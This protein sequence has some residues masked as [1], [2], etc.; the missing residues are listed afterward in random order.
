M[1]QFIWDKSCLQQ[2]LEPH[3]Q[4]RTDAAGLR[5]IQKKRSK[6]RSELLRNRVIIASAVQTLME[7]YTTHSSL[8][9]VILC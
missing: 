4:L 9:H 8:M 6:M 7:N 3:R 5:K 2:V 1:G